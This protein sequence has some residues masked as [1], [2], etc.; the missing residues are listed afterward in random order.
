MDNYYSKYI[1]YKIKYLKEKKNSN[2]NILYNSKL[3][4]GG[5]TDKIH[6]I[7]RFNYTNSQDVK[8]L[9]NIMDIVHKLLVDNNIQYHI[10]YGTLLGAI[11]S[12]GLIKW[13][14]DLDIHI[15][16]TD[17]DKLVNLKDELLKNNLVLHTALNPT[18]FGYKIYPT[19]G[20][21]I[22]KYPWK[23]PAIDIFVMT[24][25]EDILVEKFDKNFHYKIDELYPFEKYKFGN[26]YVYGPSKLHAHKYLNRLYGNDWNTYGYAQYDHKNETRRK[27]IK[28]LLTDDEKKPAEPFN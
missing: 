2:S 11:R 24:K 7:P 4:F 15:F 25:N 13:D 22:P 8:K 16:D 23:Y 19:D 20:Y 6:S 17:C 9:Y 28:V 10:S 14:D 5:S 26:N 27:R 1:K 3:Q 21:S 18:H 12:E